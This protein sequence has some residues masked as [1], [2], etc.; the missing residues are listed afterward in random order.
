MFKTLKYCH[1]ERNRR[2]N[3]KKRSS[4][5][6]LPSLKV[7]SVMNHNEEAHYDAHSGCIKRKL[8]T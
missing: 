6:K 4:T 1:N 2:K 7:T 3:V 8:E 5:E